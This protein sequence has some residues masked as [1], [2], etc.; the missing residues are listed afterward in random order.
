M[1]ILIVTGIFPPDIGGPASYVPR[2]ARALIGRGHHVEVITLADENVI[3]GRPDDEFPVHR[4][5]RQTSKLARVPR[6]VAL[7]RSLGRDADVIY[8]NGLILETML[9][10]ITLRAPV[11][12]KVVGDTVWERARNAGRR[13]DLDAFQTASLPLRWRTL[14]QLQNVYM[15]CAHRVITPSVYLKRIVTG[16][17][18]PSERINVI[19][20]AVPQGSEPLPVQSPDVDLVSVGRL[21]PWKGFEQLIDVAGKRGWSLRI[22]GDGPLRDELE[23][24][25][26]DAGAAVRFEGHLS[27]AQVAHAIRRG[28]LFV[29]NS[30]YEGLPHIVLEAMAIGV[31][32]VATAA[33]G[34]P[35]TILD[36]RTGVLVPV[37]D[38]RALEQALAELLVD[39]MRRKDLAAAALCRL[40]WE[41]SFEH[42]VSETEKVLASAGDNR[43][44]AA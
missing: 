32:V 19:Y 27:Q 26:Q 44:S 34:T 18:V 35:E 38:T 43:G 15:R 33:G 36:G 13:E 6:T 31:P 21:V 24:R 39:E 16:W 25:A 40:D 37:G 5:A 9:A 30:S 4:I 20:N 22:I 1:K 10:A 41:F 29:L 14:R 7:L 2:I 12:V 42:L 28:R 11:V 17:G 3:V 8:G 23:Q